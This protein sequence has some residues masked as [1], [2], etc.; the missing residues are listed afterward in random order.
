M[1]FVLYAF[2]LLARD[3]FKIYI[4]QGKKSGIS[5]RTRQVLKNLMSKPHGFKAV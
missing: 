3:I 1:L 2:T 4:V 5:F